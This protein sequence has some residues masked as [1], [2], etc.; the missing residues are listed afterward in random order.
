MVGGPGDDTLNGL[1]DNPDVTGL[2][3]ADIEELTDDDVLIGNEGDDSMDGGPGDDQYLPGSGDN[4]IDD[5]GGLDI[6]H[7]KVNKADIND[8]EDCIKSDCDLLIQ[9]ME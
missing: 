8:L 7:L 5:S 6:L 2:E 3:S 9:R 4:T 1:G